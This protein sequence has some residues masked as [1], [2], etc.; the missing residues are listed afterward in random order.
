[1]RFHKE[2]VM[3]ARLVAGLVFVAFVLPAAPG[4]AADL[5][6]GHKMIVEHCE[7]CHGKTGKGDGSMLKRIKADVTPVD[8]TNKTAMAKWSDAD[9]TKIIKVGGQSAGR[10]KVMPSYGEKFSDADVANLVAY[11]RSLAK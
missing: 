2:V 5:K 6:K 1:M 11:I 7:K 9:L 4:Q 3:M 8:W 10:S